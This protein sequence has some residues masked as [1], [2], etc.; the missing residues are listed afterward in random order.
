MGAGLSDESTALVKP[1][2][3]L[4]SVA[5][6]ACK[7]DSVWRSV[8]WAKDQSVLCGV[9]LVAQPWEAIG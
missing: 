5:P 3:Q 2:V 4:A 6:T 1:A 9:E 7:E 8:F